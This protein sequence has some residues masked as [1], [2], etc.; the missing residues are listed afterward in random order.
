MALADTHVPLLTSN[1]QYKVVYIG[2]SMLQRLETTGFFTSLHN[3][4]NSINLGVG[5]DK[6]ENILYRLNVG[7]W[8][9]FTA[10]RRGM[11]PNGEVKLFVLHAGTNNLRKPKGGFRTEKETR[12]Y[13]LLVRALLEMGG[14]QCKVLCTGLFRR[15][16]VKESAVT[17][18]NAEIE[19]VVKRLNQEF[20]R[21]VWYLAPP[22]EV[23]TSERW[24]E[25]H[26]H[27]TEEGYRAWDRVLGPEVRR[28]SA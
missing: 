1:T 22:E 8:N 25:D 11:F 7:L 23:D 4:S 6:L 20:V 24:L 28:L 16:D 14:E 27:L 5:G 2:D 3:Q 21:R 26:V 12:A 10:R 18:S 19:G 9:L 13:E 15:Q 17:V